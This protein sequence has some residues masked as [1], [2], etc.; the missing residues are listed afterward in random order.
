MAPTDPIESAVTDLMTRHQWLDALRLLEPAL[1]IH[2][3]WAAGWLNL[4]LC[5]LR[6]GRA[7][8]ALPALQQ[9]LALEPHRPGV[10]LAMADACEALGRSEESLTW[11]REE[12]HAFPESIQAWAALGM[13]L[14]KRGDR[15]AEAAYRQGHRLAPDAADLAAHLGRWLQHDHRLEE[16]AEVMSPALKAHPEHGRLS[17]QWTVHRFLSGDLTSGLARLDTRWRAPGFP[18]PAPMASIPLWQLGEAPSNPILVEPEQGF[19][20]TLQFLRFLGPLADR[21]HRIWLGIPKALERLVGSLP[22]ERLLI[23]REEATSA[24]CRVPLM[25]LPSRL[26]LGSQDISGAPYLCI[27]HGNESPTRT[28]RRLRVGLVWRGNPGHLNDRRR[29]TPLE[30]WLPLM[31]IE[32]IDWISLQFGADAR[33]EARA[34]IDAGIPLQ[35]RSE[36]FEDFQET[37]E[38]LLGTDL[39]IT[40]DTAMAHLAGALGHP[41]W[42]LLPYNPDWRWGLTGESTP[43]YHS[44]RLFRQTRLD[45]W[46][47]PLQQLREA[48]LLRTSAGA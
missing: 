1:E 33:A 41:V 19:G 36:E 47:E 11:C 31:R 32:G 18:A 25:S 2:S 9:G 44:M 24:A 13:A 43:W 45:S 37:A 22:V 40:V 46:P 3:R 28:R 42:V 16:A 5:W 38:H 17:W 12:N 8:Q 26:G 21:G 15:R 10:R 30:L 20:D 29:S 14:E 35:Q 6:L 48:L 7:A 23:G 34:A 27:Y 4:G 39:L